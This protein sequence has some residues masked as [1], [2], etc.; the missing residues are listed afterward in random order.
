MH[1]LIVKPASL[2]AAIGMHV[3]IQYIDVLLMQ[4]TW[5]ACREMHSKARK[6]NQVKCTTHAL[7]IT[8][9][10]DHSSRPQYW[11]KAAP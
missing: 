7:N 4:R 6:N 3:L 1:A 2:H 9:D 5:K 8:H 10:S 11:G